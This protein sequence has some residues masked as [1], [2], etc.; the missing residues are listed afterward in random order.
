MTFAPQKAPLA[1]VPH[2]SPNAIENNRRILIVDDEQPI[3]EV[4][5]ACLSARY[6]CVTATSVK[7]ALG[8]LAREPFA[9]VLTDVYMPGLRGV[10]LLREVVAR[11]PDTAVML[12]RW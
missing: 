5:A 6:S 7:E 12:F 11:Y 1:A 3:R 10:E 4:F 8:H 2:L 9:I